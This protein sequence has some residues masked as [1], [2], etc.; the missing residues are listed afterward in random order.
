MTTSN[1]GM[2]RWT[3]T[4]IVLGALF[5]VAG[6]G[7][8]IYLTVRPSAA[9]SPSAGIATSPA[10]SSSSAVTSTPSPDVSAG[11]APATTPEGWVIEPET[12][13]P[14]IFLDAMFRAAGT[15]NTTKSTYE[16]WVAYLKSWI[17]LHPLSASQSD[18]DRLL[19]KYQ[20]YLADAIPSEQEWDMLDRQ[21]GSM[22]FELRT[23]LVVKKNA[24]FPD[25]WSATGEVNIVRTYAGPDGAPI[26][27]SEAAGS[28]QLMAYCAPGQP[29]VALRIMDGQN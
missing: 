18:A 19:G 6:A 4:L 20:G 21:A 7:A 10:P 5:V 29:C 23:P 14:E 11:T 8:G 12:E 27:F 15:F 16:E 17:N 3:L 26:T 25:T 13:D 1:A 9:P 22:T 24:V 2:S 28:I